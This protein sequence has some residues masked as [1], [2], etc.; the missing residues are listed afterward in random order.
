MATSPEITIEQRIHAAVGRALGI[1][2]VDPST[3]LHMG[4][5]PGWDSMGHMMVVLSLEKEFDASF[6]S[7]R[8][9]ELVD[10][11]SITRALQDSQSK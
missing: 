1:K 11:P 7:Y 4:T 5:T 2:L 9:P 8:L 3:P 10:I 6:P